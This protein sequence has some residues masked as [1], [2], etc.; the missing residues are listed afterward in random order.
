MSA[1]GM[2]ELYVIPHIA[3]GRHEHTNTIGFYWEVREQGRLRS[4]MGGDKERGQA[5][6]SNRDEYQR[7]AEVATVHYVRETLQKFCGWKVSNY[8]KDPYGSVYK[9]GVFCE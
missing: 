7:R 1:L 2:K 4:G 6:E 5:E 3:G 9:R 8:T